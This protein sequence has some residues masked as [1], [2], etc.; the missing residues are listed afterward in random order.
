MNREKPIRSPRRSCP[1]ALLLPIQVLAAVPD[2][3]LQARNDYTLAYLTC[4]TNV[5]VQY[6]WDSQAA[7]AMLGKH[8]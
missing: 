8:S 3:C 7:G 2:P 5:L 1:S 6:L 4:Q